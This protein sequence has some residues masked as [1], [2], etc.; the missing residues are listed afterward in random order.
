MTNT[1]LDID[2][3]RERVAS[4][5]DGARVL[6]GS[7]HEVAVGTLAHIADHGD[8][9]VAA[10]LLNALPS[11]IRVKTLAKWYNRFS[12]GQV[13]FFQDKAQ[14]NQFVAKLVP[15]WS[16]EKFDL[17][18][19]AATPFGDM[20]AEKVSKTLDIK[21]LRGMIARVANNTKSNNDGTKQV[22]DS[23]RALAAFLVGSIDKAI[24]Q[25]TAKAA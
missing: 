13:N 9:T 6:L 14:G 19:A 5:R 21:A 16:A 2:T 8:W 1:Y 22:A 20:E 18:T 11:G 3:C 15:G 17:V 12:G 24:E 25:A 10:S 23:A 7:I 4:I